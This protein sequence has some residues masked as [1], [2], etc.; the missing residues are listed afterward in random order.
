MSCTD[1]YKISAKKQQRPFP[2]R[3]GRVKLKYSSAMKCFHAIGQ[4]IGGCGEVDLRTAPST[5]DLQY[6]VRRL[7]E[8]V[9]LIN[10][11]SWLGAIRD[12]L[13]GQREQ[14]RAVCISQTRAW[15]L[16]TAMTSQEGC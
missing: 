2:L 8:A 12:S 14:C 11:E 4:A 7:G 3:H 15:Q 13:D 10:H 1:N 5:Y 9:F 6:R 16:L